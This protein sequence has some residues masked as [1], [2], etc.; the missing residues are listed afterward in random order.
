MSKDYEQELN[1]SR[2]SVEEGRLIREKTGSDQ[3]GIA[4]VL[5]SINLLTGVETTKTHDA[6]YS[7]VPTPN[8]GAE[9]LPTEL[10]HQADADPVRV[11]VI[12]FEL[13]S[14]KVFGVSKRGR[15]QLKQFLQLKAA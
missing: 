2:A 6:E 14:A 1:S 4:D 9:S 7:A 12:R 13:A 3:A 11:S 5:T 8:Q 15:S 10:H